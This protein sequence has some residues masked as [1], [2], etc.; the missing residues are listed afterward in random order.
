MAYIHASGG[1]TVVQDPVDAQVATMPKS[2]IAVL[3]RT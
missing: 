2:A 1:L 3:P